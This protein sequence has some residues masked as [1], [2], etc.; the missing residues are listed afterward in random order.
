MDELSSGIELGR[1]QGR[2]GLSEMTWGCH[3]TSGDGGGVG[4]FLF[5]SFLP[6]SSFFHAHGRARVALGVVE[7]ARKRVALVSG[8]GSTSFGQGMVKW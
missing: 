4:F 1:G 7:M 2:Y 3:F 6:L 8:I 5:F